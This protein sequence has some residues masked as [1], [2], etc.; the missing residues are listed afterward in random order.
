VW[1]PQ[2]EKETNYLRVYLAQ[3]RQ[4][5]EPDPAR[6]RYFITEARMGYRFE[7]ST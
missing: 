7:P 5:L 2:Y 4:K 1:G 3:I 6:P